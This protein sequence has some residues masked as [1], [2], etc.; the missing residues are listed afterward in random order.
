MTRIN[1]IRIVLS[2]VA[3]KNLKVHQMDVK[4]TFLNGYLD[5]EIY[6]EQHEGFS[7]LG[8]EKK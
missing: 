6:I 8:Q 3:L 1:S 2:I 5:E 7:T 4:T